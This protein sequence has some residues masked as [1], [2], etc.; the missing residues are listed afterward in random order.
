VFVAERDNHWDRVYSSRD[1]REVSW[2]QDEPELSVRLVAEAA[3]G[4]AGTD[5]AIIDAG[6]GRSRLAGRLATAGFTDLTVVD[7]SAAALEA[8][9]A[10]SGQA[11][12]HGGQAQGNIGDRIQWITADLLDWRPPRSYQV[13]H[14]RAV[15]HFLTS[16]ADRAAYLGTL[17]A[18]LH[19]GGAIIMATFAADGPG[20]CSGLPVAR[21]DAPALA[22]ELTAAYGDAV[23][24]TGHH[25]EKHLSPA[26][27]VQ[28]FTWLTARYTGV[29]PGGPGSRR[30]RSDPSS[31]G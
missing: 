5:T 10:A 26:G 7:V 13:W 17:R 31:P 19:G 23:T 15:F 18:A 24:I 4:I 6:G 1:E 8:A 27:S 9:R 20:Q 2:Y 14:D 16:P 30:S 3:A 21:Y 22:A 12:D 11:R 25:A 29:R 28:P